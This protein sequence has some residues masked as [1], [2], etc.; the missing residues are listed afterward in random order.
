[1][2]DPPIELDQADAGQ[3]E[4]MCRRHEARGRRAQL[5]LEFAEEGAGREQCQ[6][7]EPAMLR[8]LLEIVGQLAC[9]VQVLLVLG[10]DAGRLGCTAAAVIGLCLPRPV[11]GQLTGLA[12]ALRMGCQSPPAGNPDLFAARGR[13]WRSQS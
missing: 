1:M 5:R 13:G 10:V 11:I 4:V 9:E 2:R 8:L 3:V 7:M 12:A 6:R